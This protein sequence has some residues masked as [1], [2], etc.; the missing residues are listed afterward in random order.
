MR[1]L[2]YQEL[3]RAAHPPS[4]VFVCLGCLVLV[5]AYPYSVIF[6]CG[7]LAPYIAFLHARE[8]NDAC[9]TAVLPVT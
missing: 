7:C 3:R 1:T 9:Y 8:T 5:P 6:L 2:L 4:L